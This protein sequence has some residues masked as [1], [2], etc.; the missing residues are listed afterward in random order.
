MPRIWK[1]TLCLGTQQD[2][3]GNVFTFN[4]R[5]IL[6]ANRN[7]AKMLSRRVPLPCVWEHQDVDA[8]DTAA[9]RAAYARYTFGH[10]AG[11]RINGRGNLELLHD[12]PDE[13]DAEQLVKTRFVSPKVC[14]GFSDSRGGEYRGTTI[15]H[16]AATPTPVQ[17][18][19]K[20]FRL[21]SNS[22]AVYLSY[23]E[24]DMADDNDD[25][26][27]GDAEPKGGVSKNAELDDLIQALRDKGFTIS[28]KVTSLKELTI[29]VESGSV[30]AD[31]GDDDLDLDKAPADDLN[32]DAGQDATSP[33]QGAPM[34][35]SMTSRDPAV[36]SQVTAWAKDERREVLGRIKGLF[37]TGRITRPTARQ[38]QRQAG[39]VEM[40]FTQDAAPVSVLHRKLAELEKLAPN[41]AWSPK[42]TA[43]ERARLLSSTTD[44]DRPAYGVTSKEEEDKVVAEQAALAKK[45]SPKQTAK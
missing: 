9:R 2:R 43:A 23:A 19:Q 15:A 4:R 33:G 1:E 6:Q 29:A 42:T 20:P 24:P 40:S 30:G 3:D 7:C 21:L 14:P 11:N 37:Q 10:I 27:K 28:D 34:L 44:V 26:P 39:T 31:D 25:K 45:Y 36:R 5:D 13:R 16:V 38:L 8:G 41:T 17:F 18:W 22:R 32:L 35:M 12:V